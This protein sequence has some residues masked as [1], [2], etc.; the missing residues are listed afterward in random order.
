M[1]DITTATDDARMT[2]ETEASR[3]V[4]AQAAPDNPNPTADDAGQTTDGATADPSSKPA[5]AQAG[6]DP[7]SSEAKPIERITTADRS[8]ADIAARFR[9]K[10]AAAGAWSRGGTRS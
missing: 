8:R 3:E 4:T 9:E 5:P 2:A 1:S 10:R 7:P 6:V